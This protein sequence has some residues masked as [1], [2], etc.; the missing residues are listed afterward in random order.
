MTA[1]PLPRE[2]MR[3]GVEARAAD[4]LQRVTGDPDL[5]RA[6]FA[7]AHGMSILELDGRFPPDADLDAA[8]A[9]GIA[10]LAGAGRADALTSG[11]G[12]RRIPKNRDE[13]DS[14]PERGEHRPTADRR[15]APDTPVPGEA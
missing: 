2:R 10:A 13:E 1:G 3:P 4:P 12:E 15:S 8:W 6:V 5:A 7:F 14:V 11:A 9:K